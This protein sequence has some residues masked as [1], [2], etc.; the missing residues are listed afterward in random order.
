M[1][2]KYI[3]PVLEEQFIELQTLIAN[4]PDITIGD[5]VIEAGEVDVKGQRGSSDSYNV[6][7]ED[8]SK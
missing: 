5:D 7:N 8:W 1:K 4:S 3:K 2:K 6:W